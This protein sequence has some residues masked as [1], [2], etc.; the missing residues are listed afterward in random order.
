[1][2]STYKIV[3]ILTNFDLY[4]C[5]FV[6]YILFAVVLSIG[7]VCANYLDWVL[8]NKKKILHEWSKKSLRYIEFD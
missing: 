5:M 4:M 3:F 2:P 6:L 8:L 7:T 1:M